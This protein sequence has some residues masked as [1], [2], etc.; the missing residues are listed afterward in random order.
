[1]SKIRKGDEQMG[2]M[3]I[4]ALAIPYFYL[5]LL[6]NL[7]QSDVKKMRKELFECKNLIRK[8][9]DKQDRRL[10]GIKVD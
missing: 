9:N 5:L 3:I 4:A 8:L 6:V 2:W 7:N 10:K 1:L